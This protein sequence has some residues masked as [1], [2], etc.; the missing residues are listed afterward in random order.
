[1]RA[2]AARGPALVRRNQS[3]PALVQHCCSS[4]LVC[5]C[6]K[7]HDER[8]S[9][10]DRSA[11]ELPVRVAFSVAARVGR[12]APR[13]SGGV[14]DGLP[15]DLDCTPPRFRA[16]SAPM[17]STE[18][19]RVHH[20]A[21]RTTLVEPRAGR[22]H[23]SLSSPAGMLSRAGIACWLGGLWL[24]ASCQSGD[25]GKE[26]GKAGSP[27]PPAAGG[28]ASTTA[29][30]PKAATPPPSKPQLPAPADV[31]APPA[32]AEKSASGLASVVLQAATGSEKPTR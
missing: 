8:D 4:S 22:A 7:P 24:I 13:S 3:G 11:E 14:G 15:S 30:A 28:A 31:A 21:S 5:S 29:A 18:T 6:P 20:I 1:M 23:P 26:A 19:N 9:L 27:N 25:V 17:R 10:T 2:F 12:R 32:T 16:D